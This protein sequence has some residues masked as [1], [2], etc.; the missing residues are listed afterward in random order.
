MRT[1]IL[2]DSVTMWKCNNFIRYALCATRKTLCAIAKS[3][4]WRS[5]VKDQKVEGE[6]FLLP[7]FGEP[8]PRHREVGG[9]N[10]S[11]RCLSTSYRKTPQATDTFKDS[12]SPNN[13]SLALW[14]AA[15]RMEGEIPRSSEP[16]MMAHGWLKGT[17]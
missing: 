17:S 9:G 11:P 3:K 16:I 12:I 15:L 4:G 5:K 6:R 13:G 1:G 8:V 2:L 10:Y 14:S 7:S